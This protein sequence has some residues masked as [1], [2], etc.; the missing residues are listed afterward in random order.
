MNY[1]INISLVWMLL[2]AGC[3]NLLKDQGGLSDAEIIEMIQYADKME[4]SMEDIPTQSRNVV[5][6]EYYD[7]MDMAAW[8]APGIGYQIDL[9]GLGHRSGNRNEVYFN[10][11]GRKLDPADGGKDDYDRRGFGK[12][13]WQCFDLVFP[14]TFEMPDGSSIT[15][16]SDGEEEWQEIKSWYDDNPESEQKPV[17]QFPVVIFFDEES[18]TIQN[19]EDLRTAYSGCRSDRE[20]RNGW[21]RERGCFELVYPITFIMPD[22]SSMTVESDDENGWSN[23]KNWYDENPGFEEEMPEF[24]YPVDILY[25]TENEDSLVAINNEEEMLEA[26]DACR[27]DWEEGY[28]RECFELVFPITY[29]MPDGSTIIVEDEDGYMAIRNWYVEN[30]GYDEEK[31]ELEYPVNIV[32]GTEEGEET[33]TINSEEEMEA[34]K[35][36]CWEE[37]GEE[38]WDEGDY[39]EGDYDEEDYDD[40]GEDCFELVLPVTYV[41]PDGSTITIEND[42]GWYYVQRWYE[43]NSDVE[44]EPGFQYPVDIVYETEDGEETVTINSEEELEVAYEDCEDDG[45]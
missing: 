1:K 8:K 35:R 40:E 41:M 6:H 26:K 38:D 39:D 14:I 30:E 7:Y 29:T 19:T 4:V 12:E 34:A 45:E 10:S 42:E 23:L 20:K 11:E 27:D 16:G 3:S 2:M 24:Q 18:I 13:D 44:E 37:W 28:H 33:V 5:E 22:G 32:Y 25:Q 43:E 31:P 21:S 17:M 36:E 9:A 15:V